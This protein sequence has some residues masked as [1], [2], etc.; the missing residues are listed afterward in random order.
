MQSLVVGVLESPIALVG[1]RVILTCLFWMAGV[2]GLFNFPAVVQEMR[3]ACLP[4][5]ELFA[6]ATIGCQL[7]GSAIIITNI[8]GL[9]WL[10]AAALGV[11]TLLSIPIGHAFWTFD[12]PRRTHEFHIALEHVTVVGGLLLAAILSIRA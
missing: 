1:G 11:F 12:E 2:Y 8:A 9:G 6:I 5:P 10:G 4:S 7:I 3:D